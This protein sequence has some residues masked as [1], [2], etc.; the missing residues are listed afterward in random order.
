MMNHTDIRVTAIAELFEDKLLEGKERFNTINRDKGYP[1]MKN[2]H[3]FLGSNAYKKLL[4]RKDIDAVLVSTPGFLHPQHLEAVVAAGKHVYCEKPIAIDAAGI[5]RIQHAG[6]LAEGRITL[7]VGFQ[8]RSASTYMEM[9]RRIRRGDIGDIVNIQGYYF[10]GSIPLTWPAGVSYDEARLRTWYWFLA[11]SG[12]ILVDQG[13]HVLDICNWALGSHPLRATG[14]GGRAGRNDRGDVWSHY[15]VLLEY[16]NDVHAGFEST[17]YDPGLGD[18]CVRF[19]GTKGIAEAHYT[20]GVFIKGDNPWDSGLARGTTETISKEQWAAGTFT[21]SLHD[22]DSNKQKAFA[23][24]IESGNL[25]N[26]AAAGAES[27]LT[28][29]LGRTASRAERD[30]TWEEVASSYDYMDPHMDLTQFDKI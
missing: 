29:I 30:T 11:L 6:K 16:P 21:S 25:L 5:K 20:G 7:A 13:I 9:V 22:A 18:V 3:L 23:A 28:A 10:A 14:T 26:E 1:E 4:D 19:F 15:Q 2:S 17:Q 8:I 12:G 27:A 24:S